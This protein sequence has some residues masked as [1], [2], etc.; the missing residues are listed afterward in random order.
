[1]ND[2]NNETL[3]WLKAKPACNYAPVVLQNKNE[4]LWLLTPPPSPTPR[5]EE[6]SFITIDLTSSHTEYKKFDWNLW[7]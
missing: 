5:N 3:T 6:T 7:T 4:G 1:M 2:K